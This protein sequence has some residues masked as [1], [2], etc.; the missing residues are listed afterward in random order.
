MS[1]AVENATAAK[2]SLARM[3]D[4]LGAAPASVRPTSLQDY[5][6][7]MSIDAPRD[8]RDGLST[9]V[10]AVA[11]Y[12]LWKRHRWLGAIGGASIGRNLPAIVSGA[13]RN[14]GL[15]NMGQT[16][17]GLAASLYW[18]KHPRWGFVLG[19]LAGG[20]ITGGWR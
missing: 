10:G 15:A 12:Y 16:G 6:R 17:A 14:I 19:W 13:D 5:L 2:K 1:N 11:G 9:G 20:L 18:K 8:V 4:V 3:A 7:K